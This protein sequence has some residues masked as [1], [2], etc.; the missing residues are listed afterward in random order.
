MNSKTKGRVGFTLIELLVVIAII[1]ILIALL[2]PAVQKVREAAAAT[3]CQNNMKQ[4]VLACH[5]FHDANKRFQMQGDPLCGAGNG[6][7]NSSYLVPIL[8]YLEQQ[9]I[10]DHIYNNGG[11]TDV[12]DQVF[13]YMCPMDPRNFSTTYPGWAGTSYVG[14]AG[15]SYHSTAGDQIGVFN[16]AAGSNLGVQV[17]IATITDGASNTVMIGERPPS[18]DLYWG[19]WS[20]NV[21]YDA[22]SGSQNSEEL[23]SFTIGGPMCSPQPPGPCGGANYV[24][25]GGPRKVG[26]PCSMNQLW[27]CHTAGAFFGFA[28]GGIRFIS[29]GVSAN[30]VPDLSTIRGNEMIPEYD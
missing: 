19:W 4:I 10:Y 13:A 16:Q 2:V 18:C 27:S 6:T 20:F 25:G 24:F 11:S 14:I 23:S 28:D 7:A 30:V 12:V 29:Y 5:N 9:A 1:A 22:V 21:G 3:Q 8:P 26:N 17:T 15:W